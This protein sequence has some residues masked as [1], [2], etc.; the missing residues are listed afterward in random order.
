MLRLLVC[1]FVCLFEVG[2]KFRIHSVYLNYSILT[3]GL[4][5]AIK[6]NPFSLS[7]YAQSLN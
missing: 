1:L 5:N 7:T 6:A 2:L 4:L 3:P